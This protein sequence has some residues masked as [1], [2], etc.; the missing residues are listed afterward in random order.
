MEVGLAKGRCLNPLEE[1]I[2]RTVIYAD[3]FNF[4]MSSREIAHFL[5]ADKAYSH[6]EIDSVLRNS[7]A[8]RFLIESADELW[9]CRG[10]A[11]LIETRR[12]REYASTQLW[13]QALSC[14]RWLSYLPFVRMVA[15]TGALAMRNAA[16][17][18]DDID[19]MLVTAPG[20]VWMARLFAVVLVR[21][22]KLRGVTICPNYVLSE[23]ALA[24]SRHSLYIAHEV[25]QMIPL[26]G[27]A[28]YEKMRD[29]NAWVYM[30]MA[31]ASQPFYDLPEGKQSR[32]SV[33]LKRAAEAVLGGRIGD[34]L[35]TW[36][37]R[38]KMQRF[39]PELKKPHAAAH[40]DRD[41]VKGHF[42]DHGH[43]VLRAY[44][45]R[46]RAHGVTESAMPLAG[47]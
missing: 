9:F 1:A 26:H 24:Q 31:N 41:H 15:L 46:L 39:A 19:Y 22:A 12:A 2:L 3:V 13:S 27:R 21:L 7:Q 38:R 14:G 35:D 36:E 33:W 20:R 44:Q 40:L 11:E 29:A 10:R 37:R 30:Q 47:D 23:N 42:D 6:A 5:I 43:F 8:L 4:P 28:I 18:T 16:H 32:I 45:E 17:A 25:V 34:A